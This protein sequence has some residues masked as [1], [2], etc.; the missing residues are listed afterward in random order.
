MSGQTT[1]QAQAQDQQ[2]PPAPA[3]AD[4]SDKD[5]IPPCCTVPAGDPGP[6][7]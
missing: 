4:S 1:N 7:T 5:P 3:T 6:S 2:L